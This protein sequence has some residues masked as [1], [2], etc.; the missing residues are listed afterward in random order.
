[1]LQ[2]IVERLSRFVG[3]TDVIAQV[4]RSEF[5]IVHSLDPADPTGLQLASTVLAG[6]ADPLGPV[7][8]LELAL[9]AWAGVSCFP[10][11]SREPETLL[12]FA[13]TAL[14]QARRG[15]AQSI[16]RYSAEMTVRSRHRLAIEAHL[17][18][19]IEAGQ[20]ELMYQPQVNGQ[21]DLL[22]AEALLRWHSPTFGPV[23]PLEWPRPFAWCKS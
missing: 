6:V 23:S 15:G 10:E 7:Q 4:G 1:M 22:G 18:R 16:L 3:P 19:A 12:L 8:T 2:V 14:G 17:Q 20:L 11:D 9:S 13:S 5:L 21:G